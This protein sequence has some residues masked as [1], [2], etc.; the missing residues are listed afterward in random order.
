MM[1]EEIKR[2]ISENWV[3]H[4]GNSMGSD[5]RDALYAQTLDALSQIYPSPNS[6]IMHA[7][8]NL[9]VKSTTSEPKGDGK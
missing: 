4:W 6:I 3:S 7:M 5:Q 2:I 9:V 8:I 1:E